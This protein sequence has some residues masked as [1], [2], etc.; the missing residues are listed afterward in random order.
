MPVKEYDFPF[1]TFRLI[2]GA[3]S[4]AGIRRESHARLAASIVIPHLAAIISILVDLQL[5]SGQH[6]RVTVDIMP[7]WEC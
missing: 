1:T 4:R 5:E 7:A 3:F 2:I 6:S